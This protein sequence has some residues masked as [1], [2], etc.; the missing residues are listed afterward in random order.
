[1]IKE[2]RG[3]YCFLSNYFPAPVMLDGIIY[4]TNE[5]AFAA[6]KTLDHGLRITISHAVSPGDAK[7]IGRRLKL[8]DGW[9]DMRNEVM[10]R[11][12]RDKFVRNIELRRQLLDTGIQELIEGNSWRDTYWGV[13]NGVGQ[14]HLGKILMKVRYQL[15]D[16]LNNFP[17]EPISFRLCPRC[18]GDGVVWADVCVGS[19]TDLIED[20][21]R[22]CYGWGYI[23][24]E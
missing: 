17:E 16:F 6:A 7:K 15:R 18:N 3:Q 23:K 19:G 1:M 9:D 5:H 21:C 22:T 13:C 8:R 14:N 12:V 10:E 20:P 11:L 24:N 2:F 4:P